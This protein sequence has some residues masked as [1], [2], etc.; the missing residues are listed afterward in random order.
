M[1]HLSEH[2]AQE[3]HFSAVPGVICSVSPRGPQID[4][5]NAYVY[6]VCGRIC[7]CVYAVCG[8]GSEARCDTSVVV[9]MRS[10]SHACEYEHAFDLFEI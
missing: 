7:F 5:R 3:C 9:V 2:H 8:H 6:A 4:A 10:H 1:H